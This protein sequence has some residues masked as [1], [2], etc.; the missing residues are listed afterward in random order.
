MTYAPDHRSFYD[1][2]SHVMEL[3]NFIIDYADEEFKSL[4]PPVN[5]KASLVTDEE[6]EAIINNGGKHT[7]DHVQAQIDLG[8]R[9]IAESKEI[10][11]LGAFDRDDR[12][13]AMDLLGFKKQLVFATHSVVTPFRDLRGKAKYVDKQGVKVTPELRYGATRA[14]NRAMSDFCSQDNRLMGVGVIPLHE[15]ELALIELD[16]AIKSGL[17]AIWI[18]HYAC[19]DRSPGHVALDPFWAKLSESGIPFLMHVGGSPLQLDKS[20][21]DNGKPPSKDWMGGGENVRAK[22]MVVMH[23]GPETFISMMVLDGVFERHPQL[24]GASIELG[25]G[26]VPEMLKRLDYV[27]KTWSRVD[28]NL[29]EIKRKPSE[30]IIEQMAFTPFHH[31]DVG[32]LID[33]SHPELYLFS[34]DYPHVEGTSDTIGR[35]ERFLTDYDETIKDQFYSE[36]FLRLSPNARV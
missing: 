19:G 32:M 36:N 33:T 12:S 4:I 24:K 15:P 31:E 11:A 28:K 35:F 20:W 26:W 29:S 16:F 13:I 27:V 9:L 25:A 3:P 5:Y 14:H 30:Q 21:S 17:E 34:S 18:P 10:Q 7:K 23:Q 8:D 6:V 2:D 22:D 1:A